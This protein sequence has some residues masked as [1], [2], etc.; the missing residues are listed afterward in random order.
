MKV[1]FFITG[2]FLCSECGYMLVPELERDANDVPTGTVLLARHSSTR[3][4]REARLIANLPAVDAS[5]E[6]AEVC[7]QNPCGTPGAASNWVQNLVVFQWF[8][9]KGA[10]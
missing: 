1:R 3:R 7:V 2:N 9:V 6:L 8:C 5:T 10:T 4:L